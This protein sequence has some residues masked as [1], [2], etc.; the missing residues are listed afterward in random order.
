M[1][2]SNTVGNN[3]G[4]T[5]PTQLNTDYLVE[6]NMAYNNRYLNINGTKQTFTN[7]SSDSGTTGQNY[8]YCAGL[9]TGNFSNGLHGYAYGLLVTYNSGLSYRTYF[10][11][12]QRKID[13]VCGFLCY[14]GDMNS[15]SSNYA[16]QGFMPST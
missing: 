11:P 4:G 2:L 10:I 8:G 1:V 13:G 15:S 16:F 6:S 12:A 14:K 5:T 7:A 3:W 9:D